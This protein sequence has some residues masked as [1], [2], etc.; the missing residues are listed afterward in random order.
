MLRQL[1]LGGMFAFCLLIVLFVAL[2]STSTSRPARR[3]GATMP[4][5]SPLLADEPAPSLP[6]NEEETKP[7]PA[8][9]STDK[10]MFDFS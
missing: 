4:P 9:R 8:T 1:M 2:R 3:H 5:G 10:N 6:A 7:A